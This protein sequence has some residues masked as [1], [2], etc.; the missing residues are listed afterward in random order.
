MPS[1]S[2]VNRKHLSQAD[3]V[4]QADVWLM[5]SDIGQ[6]F[7]G[8]LAQNSQSRIP[9]GAATAASVYGYRASVGMPGGSSAGNAAIPAGEPRGGA[10][11]Q[12]NTRGGQSSTTQPAANEI[13]A[14]GNTRALGHHNPVFWLLV[15]VLLFIGFLM[16]AFDVEVPKL[17]GF[18]AHGGK[19]E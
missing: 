1:G 19:K 14:V 9:T 4:D 16:F 5:Q 17:G 15:L 12:V 8:P 10:N 2:N 3:Y 11:R 6:T 13:A 7:G 18:E